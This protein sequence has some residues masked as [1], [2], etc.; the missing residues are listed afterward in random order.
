MPERPE[1]T[2]AEWAWIAGL[3]EGEGSFGLTDGTRPRVEINMTDY[4]VILRIA[5][6]LQVGKL[7]DVP[8]AKYG[9][10]DSLHLDIRKA[11]DAVWVMQSVLPW[12]GNRRAMKITQILS[13][14][15]AS[16]TPLAPGD[17]THCPKGHEYTE[18]NTYRQP[19]SKRHPSGGRRCRTCVRKQQSKA[20]S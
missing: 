16:P 17:R 12:M 20:V 3:L 2:E 8:R 10:K 11:R 13:A 18:E 5:N 14:W 15:E 1:L 6:L 4:D 19:V 9:S 7:Q